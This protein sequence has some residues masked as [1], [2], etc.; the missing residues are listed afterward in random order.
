MI[1]L[2][3]EGEKIVEKNFFN[4]EGEAKRHD[5]KE[6]FSCVLEMKHGKIDFESFLYFLYFEDF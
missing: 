3:G 1:F 4:L 5:V 2:L 6:S